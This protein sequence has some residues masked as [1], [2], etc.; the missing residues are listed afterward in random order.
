MSSKQWYY[1][2]NGQSTGPV[3]EERIIAMVREGVIPKTCLIWAKGLANWR[4][5]ESFFQL[6]D[7]ALKPVQ[8]ARTEYIREDIIVPDVNPV[9]VAKQSWTDAAPHPW[10]RFFARMI[11]TSI[12]GF[13]GVYLFSFLLATFDPALSKNLIKSLSDPDGRMWDILVTPILA[14][15]VNAAFIGITGTSIGKWFFGIKV[16]NQLNK[17]IGYFPALSREIKVWS[18][19]LAFGIPLFNLFTMSAAQKHLLK[20]GN[21]TWDQQMNLNVMQRN[22]GGK[23]A[24]LN[25]AGFF[26]LLCLIAL[27]RVQ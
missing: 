2:Q 6:E 12:N 27:L 26:I 1:M 11:D 20:Q 10:R 7:E 18:S 17:P 19:G 4:A 5:A 9:F 15:F 8:E 21:T 3:A 14:M 25:L 24:A 22:V 13:I 23:Q 16:F